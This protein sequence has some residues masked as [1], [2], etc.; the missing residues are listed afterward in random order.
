MDRPIP[1]VFFRLNSGREPVRD[2]LKDLSREN[3]KAIGEDIKTLQFG[4]PVGMPLA[5]KMEADLWEL[6]SSVSS[7]IART[8]FTIYQRQIVLLHG[9]VKKSPNTPSNELATA[10]RRLNE[11]RT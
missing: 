10:R 3:R 5:R 1:V 8:F 6:R 11:L 7:G 4:W 2:W 9:F